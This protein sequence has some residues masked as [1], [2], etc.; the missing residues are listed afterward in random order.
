[1]RERRF[2]SF[3]VAGVDDDFYATIALAPVG[4]IGAVRVLAE[5]AHIESRLLQAAAKE[6]GQE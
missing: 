2:L 6:L 1:V 4:I 5:P 3:S